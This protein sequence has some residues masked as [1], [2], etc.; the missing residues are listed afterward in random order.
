MLGVLKVLG[1]VRSDFSHLNLFYDQGIVLALPLLLVI[2]SAPSKHHA[3]VS[4]MQDLLL[5]GIYIILFV[6]SDYFY[7]NIVLLQVRHL[8]HLIISPVGVSFLGFL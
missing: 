5:Q 7:L 1:L 8:Y 3:L 2:D 6:V 4:I